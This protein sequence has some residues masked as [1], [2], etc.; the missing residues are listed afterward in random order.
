[1]NRQE[2]LQEAIK[3]LHRQKG[4]PAPRR[5]RRKGDLWLCVDCRQM[6]FVNQIDGTK[7]WQQIEDTEPKALRYY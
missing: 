2:Q 5:K 4:C 6:W 1:M 7:W 3:T